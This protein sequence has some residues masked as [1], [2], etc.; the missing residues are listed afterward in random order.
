MQ[1]VTPKGGIPIQLYLDVLEAG[2]MEQA[3]NCARLPNAFHHIA[4]MPDAHQG[5]AMPVGGVMALKGAVMPNAVGVDIGCGMAAAR[6]SMPADKAL[7]HLRTLAQETL[8]RI[9]VGFNH[10]QRPRKSPFLDAIQ[11]KGAEKKRLKQRLPVVAE[12]VDEIS[13]Q[14]GTLGGGNHFIEFQQDAEG[15]LWVMIHSGSRNIGLKIAKTYHRIAKDYCKSIKSPLSSDYAYLSLDLPEAQEYLDQMLWA[16]EFAE[17][18][19]LHMLD[20]VFEI[21]SEIF[22]TPVEKTLEVHTRHNYAAWEEHFG[23]RVLVHRKGAVRARDGELVTIPGSMGTCSYIGRGKG[24]EQSFQSCSH[25]AGRVK[26]RKQARREI[27]ERD[28]L[29]QVG[30]VIVATPKLDSIVDEAPAA[31]KNIEDVMKQQVDL[32]EIAYRL[33]PLAVVKG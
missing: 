7:P 5:F 6:T 17:Q 1:T 11:V 26:G 3:E 20:R 28:F 2:A 14:L 16:T 13:H 32:V 4:I 19:R 8:H 9:P 30:A 27:S 22:S 33:L 25:G 31:Y 12:R 18:N 21:M 15:M 23:A 29:R 10:H 24:H